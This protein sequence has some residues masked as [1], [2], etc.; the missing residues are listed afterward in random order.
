[1]IVVFRLLPPSRESQARST[2]VSHYRLAD[3]VSIPTLCRTQTRSLKFVINQFDAGRRAHRSASLGVR[4]ILRRPAS[5][6]VPAFVPSSP[7]SSHPPVP[8]PDAIGPRCKQN[9]DENVRAALV[10]PSELLSRASS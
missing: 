5:P 10:R 4:A 3:Q 1:M 6:H 9:S 8:A 2:T 7:T